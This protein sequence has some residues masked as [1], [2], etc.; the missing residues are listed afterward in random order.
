MVIARVASA[1]L[2]RAPTSYTRSATVASEAS[3][4]PVSALR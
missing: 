2:F 4:L 1:G 3:G